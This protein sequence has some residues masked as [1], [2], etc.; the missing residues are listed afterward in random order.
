MSD[1]SCTVLIVNS[2]DDGAQSARVV[3]CLYTQDGNGKQ[4]DGHERN[5]DRNGSKEIPDV[6]IAYM[7]T[8]TQLM[9]N[10]MTD[11]TQSSMASVVAG[12]T[13]DCVLKP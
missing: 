4:N 7:D 12:G 11:A 5:H 10:R 3:N 6:P 8:T 13:N 1:A 9:N 2:L